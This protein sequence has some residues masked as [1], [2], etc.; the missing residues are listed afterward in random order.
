[1]SDVL[2]I[3][4]RDK[5]IIIQ[6]LQEGQGEDYGEGTESFTD[7]ASIWAALLPS[8]GREMYLAR[9]RNAEVEAGFQIGFTHGLMA[10][11]RIYYDGRYYDIFHI[12]EVGRREAHNIYGIAQ[13]R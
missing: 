1:M 13:R 10:T 9:Q 2:P 5:R 4:R 12:E 6:K 3:G 7:W 8:S 11:M